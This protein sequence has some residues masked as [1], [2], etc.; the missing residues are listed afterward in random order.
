MSVNF[1]NAICQEPLI[2]AA[3]FG[4]CDDE[5]GEKAHTNLFET[6]KWIA[7]VNNEHRI[8]LTFTAI[9]NCVLKYN[10][11]PT[12]GR[13]DCML[14]SENHI[15]FI[16]LKNVRTSGWIPD[17]IK[18]LESTVQFFNESHDIRKFR[19]KKAFACNKKHKKFREI[20]NELNLRFFKTY[21]VRLDIQAEI[22]VI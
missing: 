7:K 19:H 14:T 13:C 17:A 4:L 8:D 6:D 21:K 3:I 20:D 16:E 18:Q 5:N 11:Q 9:D 10:E 2:N 1:F 22:I 15:Y 12:R